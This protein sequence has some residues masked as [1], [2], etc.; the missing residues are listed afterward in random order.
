MADFNRFADKLLALEG[1]F[2]NNPNDKGGPTN[3]G[4]A[5]RT[6]RNRFG[7]DKTVDDLK[8]MTDDQWSEIIKSE[9][10][11]MCKG[12]DIASQSVAEII[13]DWCVNSGP[14]QIR[15]IQFLLGVKSDGVVGPKT[16][17]AINSQDPETFFNRIKAA[18]E[19]FYHDIIA[20]SPSQRVFLKGWINR[21]DSLIFTE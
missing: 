12:D 21:L 1:G 6:F 5:L 9:Y 18:R 10:W 16:L 17:S 4:I 14:S 3:K 20:K 11:N 19:R 8:A 15:K 2:V 13:C 7:S